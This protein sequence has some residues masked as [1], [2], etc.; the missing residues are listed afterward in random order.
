MLIMTAWDVEKNAKRDFA[1]Q[2]IIQY[3]SIV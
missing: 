3:Y 2:D 1:L